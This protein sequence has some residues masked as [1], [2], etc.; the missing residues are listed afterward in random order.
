MHPD[1]AAKAGRENGPASERVLGPETARSQKRRIAEGFFA[2]YL[3]GDAILDIGFRGGRPDAQ[4]VLAHATGVDLDYP[5]YDGLR[6]P[7]ADGSQDGVFS[8]HTLEH[9]DDYRAVLADWFRVLKVSGHLVISV[10]HQHLYE[11]KASLPSRFSGNHKRFYTPASLLREIEESLP[12]AA[13]R[14]RS[15][16]DIDDGFSYAV[17]PEHHARGCYEIELVVQKI[18]P[19]FYAGQ[20]VPPPYAAEMTRFFTNL[21]MRGVAARAA[22]PGADLSELQAVLVGLPLPPFRQMEQLL[23]PGVRKSDLMAVL[24]PAIEAAPFDEASYLEKHADIRRMVESG[25]LASGRQHYL[26]GGYFEGRCL[27][28]TSRIFG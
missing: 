24:R 15:L 27:T 6:L 28:T 17:P 8:S 19:P 22:D 26:S 2:R 4:P 20:L 23:P 12:V 18:D 14:V 13:Y 9:V 3:S 21:V 7:F 16:R 1:Q 5:G 11:R 10:P 25:R